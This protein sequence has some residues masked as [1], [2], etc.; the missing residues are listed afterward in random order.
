MMMPG[1][2][3]LRGFTLLEIIIVLIIMGALAALGLPR[4]MTT[5]ERMRAKEGEQILL[6]LLSAQKRYALDHSGS[7]AASFSDL[8]IDLRPLSY[9]GTPNVYNA[10]SPLAD[11]TRTGSYKLEI[12]D[13]AVI[14]CSGGPVNLCS[15]MGY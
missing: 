11:I 4:F 5:V 1:K 6:T 14:S 9:F 15:Q 8:D 3:R 2:N 7:Y 12:S 13:T 10:A